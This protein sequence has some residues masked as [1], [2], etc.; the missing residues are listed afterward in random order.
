MLIE[1]CIYDFLILDFD[2]KRSF[3]LGVSDSE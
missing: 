3:I 2:D 1:T